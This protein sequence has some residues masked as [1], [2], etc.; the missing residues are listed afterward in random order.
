MDELR[1]R[2]H[3]GSYSDKGDMVDA[4][5]HADDERR[6]K[7]ESTEEW[8]LLVDDMDEFEEWW[9]IWWSIPP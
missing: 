6:E 5:E 2:W 8:M 9:I 3:D 1:R 7:I 4:M